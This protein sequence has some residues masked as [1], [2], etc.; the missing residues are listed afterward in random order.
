M[1]FTGTHVNIL[2][3][4]KNKKHFFQLNG[5]TD[6]LDFSAYLFLIVCLEDSDRLIVF[7]WT[8][9]LELLAKVRILILLFFKYVNFIIALNFIISKGCGRGCGCCYYF[10]LLKLVLKSANYRDRKLSILI[11][12]Q[13]FF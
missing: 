11:R 6:S 7:L 4:N 8:F 5:A 10:G 1:K 3:I 9:E 12:R 2:A 13:L